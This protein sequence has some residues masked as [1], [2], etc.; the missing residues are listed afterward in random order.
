MHISQIPLGSSRHVWTRHDTF[1]VSS[2]CIL[3]VLSSSNSTA[4]HA[5]LD[6]LDTSNG[7]RRDVTSQVEFG[8]IAVL[9]LTHSTWCH[10]VKSRITIIIILMQP[11]LPPPT[12]PT[13]TV[14]PSIHN[15]LTFFHSSGHWNS[16]YLAPP[17]SWTGPGTGKAGD[18]NHR[19]L[20]RDH[21]PVPAV[22]SGFA[23]GERGLVSE[24]VH[25]RLACWN[26]LFT[27]L[28][29]YGIFSAYGFV[30]AGQIIIIILILI[31]RTI[32][33]VLSSS[34]RAICEI[35]LW[36]LLS[37]SRSAPGDI[38]DDRRIDLLYQSYTLY[39]QSVKGERKKQIQIYI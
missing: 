4:R 18:H 8:N 33:I 13:N 23:K 15:S 26:Q 6:A 28:N 10:T 21:L 22:I 25:S 31:H 12:R 39:I 32:F 17:G 24:H 16:R 19:R 35:S 2:P 9:H 27:F 34:A 1:D 11:A 7:S 14:Q 38:I 29:F 5:H 37:E 3:A 20:Q 30:L 36:V